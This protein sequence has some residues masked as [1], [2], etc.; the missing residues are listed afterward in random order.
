M[1]L[2]PSRILITG[3]AGSGKTWLGERL[4]ARLGL[5]LL[6]LDDVVWDGPYGGK[7]RAKP[8]A[9]A[10][11]ERQAADGNWVI[12][13]VYG[14]LVPAALPRATTFVFVDLP[15]DECIA[16][17]RARG[18]QGG[19]DAAA[20]DRMLEWVAAYPQRTNANSLATHERLFTE[21]AGPKQRLTSR[22]EIAAWLEGARPAA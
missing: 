17:L 3:N 18:Q 5:P 9:Y 8:E 13:G 14:W 10:E 19:G 16:N 6:H 21:F 2:P 20:F 11:A 7:E 15:V 12:E 4:S 1:T 22:A